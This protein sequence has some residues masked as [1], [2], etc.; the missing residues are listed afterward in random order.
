MFLNIHYLPNKRHYKSKM[1]H[2]WSNK[3]G[4]GKNSLINFL[5]V[6][7]PCYRWPDDNWF[8]HYE[9]NLYQFILWDEFRL[10][11]QSSEFLKRFFAGD[12]MRL[13]VKGSHAYKYDNPLVIFTSNY[14]FINSFMT[15]NKR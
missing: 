6:I 7:S 13:P 1:L 3:P 8:D 5:K 4:L 9:N 15:K 11:R 14:S 12:Q 2:L 10:T